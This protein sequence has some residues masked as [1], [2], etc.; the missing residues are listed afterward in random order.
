MV[1]GLDTGSQLA[2]FIGVRA[3]RVHYLRTSL[4]YI[5]ACPAAVG[6]GRGC[7]FLATG[8]IEVGGA[9]R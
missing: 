9:F 5:T 1:E 4:H 8:T 2:S 6:G 3:K 7:Y